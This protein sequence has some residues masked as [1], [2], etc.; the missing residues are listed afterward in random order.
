MREINLLDKSAFASGEAEEWFTWLRRNDP[1]HHHPEPG[2]PGFWVL[3]KHA[4]IVAASADSESFSADLHHGGPAGLTEAERLPFVLAAKRAKTLP[5]MEGTEHKEQRRAVNRN[6]RPNRIA[7]MEDTV[8]ARVGRVLDAAADRRVD[9]VS[10]VAGPISMGV[11][12]ELID[13]PERDHAR[14]TRVAEATLVPDD[15]DAAAAYAAGGMRRRDTLRHALNAVSE[16]RTDVF[17]FLPF[18]RQI[19][20]DQRKALLMAY[21]GRLAL[22]RYAQEMIH[23]RRAEPRDDIVTELLDA[24]VGDRQMTDQE[25]VHYLELLLTAGHETS[26]TTMTY[27]IQALSE[28]PE[29]YA[30]IREDPSLIPVAVE[31]LLRWASP[32]HYF[33]RMALTDVEMRGKRIRRGDTVAMWFS[34]GNRDEE[35]FEDPFRFDIRRNPNP[36][37]AFGG[38]GRHFCL[39]NKLARLELRVV[40]EELAARF[41]EIRCGSPERVHSSLINGVKHLEVEMLTSSRAPVPVS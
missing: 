30:A 15:P 34:S 3:A 22:A 25:I 29:Q 1:V 26:R 9:F 32:V 7:A 10:E 14:L 36:H 17:R 8:R 24:K 4:D 5:G 27:G 41:P 18:L 23:A 2:G 28:H 20:S 19:T 40:L 6:W 37:V 11:L 38:G 16:M 13:V 12:A 31:E 35:V 39:G 33:R 21:S